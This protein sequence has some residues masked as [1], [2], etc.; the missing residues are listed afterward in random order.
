MTNK[1]NLRPLVLFPDKRLM[2]KTPLVEKITKVEQQE[3]NELDLAMHEYEGIGLAGPQIGIMKQMFVVNYDHIIARE[4]DSEAK[5]LGHALFMADLQILETSS[6]VQENN[7]GCLSLPGIT[8]F[9][10][11]PSS[12]KVSYLDFDGERK[13]LQAKGLL[14]AC[15]LHE[16]DHV[17]GKLILDYQSRLKREMLEKKILKTIKG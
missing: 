3:F 12:I 4:Q 9:V 1:T 5:P 7:E 10:K 16:N 2:I 13:T 17:N 6:E 8:A 11:R 14:A 15:I